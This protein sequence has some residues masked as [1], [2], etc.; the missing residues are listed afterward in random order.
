MFERIYIE[1]TVRD[2]CRTVGILK[3]FP[4]AEAIPCSRY[5][6]I[7]NLKRQNFRV[8]K[9]KPA[10]ILAEKQ[11]TKVLPT[12]AEYG[13]GADRHYY[14]SHMLN[15][16]Y[17]CRYCFLQGMYR[18]SNFVLFVNY[19][20]FESE[21]KE[22]A[23]AHPDE[24]CIFFSG[25]DCDSL[26]LESLTGFAG[27]FLQTF[28][29]LPN[30][31]LELRTKSA[32]VSSLLEA[33]PLTNVVVAFTLSPDPVAQALEHKAPTL[34]ARIRAIKK[35]ASHGWKIG[36]RFDPLIY[37][38]NC[39]KVYRDFVDETLKQIPLAAIHSITLGLF[40]SPKTIFNNMESLYPEEPLF[41]G[42]LKLSNG[43]VR[44][45]EEVETRFA[46]TAEAQILKHVPEDLL[47]R[48]Q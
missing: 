21:I 14:F 22:V 23:N 36:L 45:S 38:V 47:F 20:D 32:K 12:P 40:R 10:L 7:F 27:H 19:E 31:T 26:A 6:E 35:L 44:Y 24:T 1:D 11:G 29:E 2:H 48:Q 15:C 46:E 9:A 42:N 4:T 41:M 37:F 8:Q 5:G 18:S 34:S 13:L 17:D 16:L 43:I 25:Y 28:R 39:E 3:K 33:K 30:S